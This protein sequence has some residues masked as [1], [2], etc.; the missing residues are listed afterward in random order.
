MSGKDDLPNLFFSRYWW[1][2]LHTVHHLIMQQHFCRYHCQLKKKK[3]KSSLIN[4]LI[5][6][7]QTNVYS[8][9]VCAENLRERY[10]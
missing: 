5:C 7:Y 4:H 6:H 2:A 9:Y 1:N 3:K 8:A 10:F